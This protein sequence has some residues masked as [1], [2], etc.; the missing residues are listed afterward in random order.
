MHEKLLC[1]W[2]TCTALKRAQLGL[3]RELTFGATPTV[4]DIQDIEAKV[5]HVDFSCETAMAEAWRLESI[6]VDVLDEI[7]AMTRDDSEGPGGSRWLPWHIEMLKEF[8][9]QE[10]PNMFADLVH[11]EILQFFLTK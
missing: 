4:S 3:Q 10:M 5:R 1:S 7:A 11:P 6:D 9:A 8:A 2:R